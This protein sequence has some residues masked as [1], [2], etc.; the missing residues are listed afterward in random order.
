M[1][2]EN[3]EVLLIEDDEDDAEM[4]MYTLAKLKDLHVTHINDGNEAITYLLDDHAMLPDL[5]LLDLKMPK[6]DGVEVLRR[7]KAHL[8]RTHIPV[9]AFISSPQGRAYLESF[10]LRAD[11]YLMKPVDVTSFLIAASAAGMTNINLSVKE[12]HQG[13]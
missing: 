1:K 9:I 6:V 8:E 5:I 7:I 4:T 13:R 11:A 10:Q 3:F 2:K 12:L